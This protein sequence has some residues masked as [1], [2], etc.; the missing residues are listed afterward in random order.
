MLHSAIHTVKWLPFITVAFQ[1]FASSGAT[2]TTLTVQFVRPKKKQMGEANIYCSSILN[3]PWS[4]MGD[5]Q[6]P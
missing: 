6:L 2:F 3:E 4:G 1:T 5:G